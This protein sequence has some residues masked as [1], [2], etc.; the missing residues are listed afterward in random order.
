M[1]TPN[2]TANANS[3]AVNLTGLTPATMYRYQI[4]AM[5][6]QGNTRTTADAAFTTPAQ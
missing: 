3:Y 5:D 2:N 4:T 6:A 1:G